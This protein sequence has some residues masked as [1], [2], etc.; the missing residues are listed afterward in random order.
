MAGGHTPSGPS[1]D[2]VL[3]C[4]AA[5]G[6]T[7]DRRDPAGDSQ[8]RVL[9]DYHQLAVDAYAAQHASRDAGGDIP[10]IGVAYALVGLHLALDRGVPGLRVRAAHQRMGK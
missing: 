8:R 1:G 5:A 2:V 10:P 9:R 6:L 3:T 7:D 4:P